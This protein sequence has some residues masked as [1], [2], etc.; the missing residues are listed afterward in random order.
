MLEKIASAAA[1]VAES[2][3]TAE[4]AGGALEQSAEQ[5]VLC[6]PC[7][8]ELPKPI[9]GDIIKNGPLERINKRP[10]QEKLPGPEIPY[11]KRPD[12]NIVYERPGREELPRMARPVRI[13]DARVKTKLTDGVGEIKNEGLS[14]AEKAMIQKETGWSDE[15]ID[16][17]SSMEEYE[18]YKK[19][20]LQEAEING[21]KCLIRGDIDW[22]QKDEMGRTNRERVQQGLSP[23]NKDGK[24]IEL[25]HI[26]QHADSPLAELTQEEHRGK[27]NYHVLHHKSG[28]SE[29]DRAV[30]GVERAEHWE[31]RATER[32]SS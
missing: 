27:E 4:A 26:G 31:N 23:Y 16:A 2:A 17:I 32:S 3:E 11:E 30:F 10:G 6:R 8:E 19:A 21:R 13:E 25:H 5:S 9:D 14:A 24:V 7:R 29:I 15:I 1:E 20:G 22:E 28:E 18:I 12:I